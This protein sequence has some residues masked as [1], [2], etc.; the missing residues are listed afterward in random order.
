MV[1]FTP[2]TKKVTAEEAQSMDLI[3]TKKKI[4]NV[5]T[6]T[7]PTTAVSLIR[8]TS[9]LES[10]WVP[11]V[12]DY[13]HDSFAF[14]LPFDTHHDKNWTT[15]TQLDQWF[16]ALHPSEFI[17]SKHSTVDE[18][19]WTPAMHH[20]QPLLRQTAWVTLDYPHC[21]CALGY[22]DT[23]Q[24]AATC[25][26]FRRVIAEITEYIKDA[27][28][29][30]TFNACT[31][32]YYPPGGGVNWHADDAF[33]WGDKHTQHNCTVSLSLCRGT[34]DGILAGA[35]KFR[36]KPKQRQHCGLQEVVLKHGDLMTME[37]HVQDY[38]VH[39]VWPGDNFWESGASQDDPYVQG[40]RINLT[41]R[42]I[43]RHLDGSPACYGKTCP[44][45][46][47][48][49]SSPTS[50]VSEPNAEED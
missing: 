43:V 6:T 13:V 39:S 1:K 41:W 40:E 32:T 24:E 26:I 7:K 12:T 29:C 50:T 9:P 21:T 42:T 37:G 18:H 30:T 36:I 35:R 49:A 25:P 4:E 15:Y 31:L 16:D 34:D 11:L 8:D 46:Q 45:S 14:V 38:Y 22:S 33:L 3:A 28:G 47:N 23:W 48:Q 17:Q 10:D 19:A 27:T 5:E 20:G 2:D 44:M